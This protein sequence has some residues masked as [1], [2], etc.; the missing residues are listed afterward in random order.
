M[1]AGIIDTF[2]QV[3]IAVGIAV[4][5]AIFVGRGA[6]KVRELATETPAASGE[7]SRELGEAASSGSLDAALAGLPPGTWRWP[8]T[9]QVRASSRDSTMCSRRAP[10][11]RRRR[12]RP[13]ARSGTRDR[14]S[15]GRRAGRAGTAARAEASGEVG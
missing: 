8:R 2:R 10:E 4:W 9:P 5:G 3:G 13:L 11:L 12:P 6:D 1:A 15:D 7:R 14:A